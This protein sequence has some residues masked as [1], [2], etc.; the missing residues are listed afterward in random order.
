MKETALIYGVAVI[1]V[2]VAIIIFCI[3][4]LFSMSKH[5]GYSRKISMPPAKLKPKQKKQWVK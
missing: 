2:C 1:I 4:L 3:I 5:G